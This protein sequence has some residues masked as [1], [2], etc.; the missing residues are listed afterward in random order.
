M[1]RLRFQKASN[2]FAGRGFMASTIPAS[3]QWHDWNM[4]ARTKRLLGALAFLVGLGLTAVLAFGQGGTHPP[5]RAEDAVLVILAAIAQG[6]SV[7]AIRSI[8]HADPAHVRQSAARL[9]TVASKAEQAERTAQASFESK[10]PAGELRTELGIAS[11]NFSWIVE[12][13]LVS[14]EDWRAFYPDAMEEQGRGDR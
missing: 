7:L 13:L 9:L 4:S 10:K 8:G 11:T 2:S 1:Q 3:A 12:M 6:G 14:I 5:S